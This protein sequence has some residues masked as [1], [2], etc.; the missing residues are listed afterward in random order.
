MHKKEI[1]LVDDLF[2]DNCSC[3]IRP[4]EWFRNIYKNTLGVPR[5]HFQSDPDELVIGKI[6]MRVLPFS[7]GGRVSTGR[8]GRV[9][10]LRAQRLKRIDR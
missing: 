4:D 10:G 2:P 5:N 8:D 7:S 1:V 6:I 9:G 3:G